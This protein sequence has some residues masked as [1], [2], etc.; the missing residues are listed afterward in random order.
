MQAS[1]LQNNLPQSTITHWDKMFRKN[2][3][4]Q[5]PFVA[6]TVRIDFPIH[7][8]N[9]YVM[10]MYP[11]LGANTNQAAEGVAP[12]SGITASVLQS[13]AVIGEY[14]D[15]ATFSSRALATAIDPV[16]ENIGTEM[17]YRLGQSDSALV[18]ITADAGTS[19]DSSILVKLA[20]TST[21]VF[22]TLSLNTI[23]NQV[24]SL[25]GRSVHP[26]QGYQNVFPGVI[27]PFALGD[28]LADT[29]NNSP[30]DIAKHTPAGF[31][32]LKDYVSS[33]I[34][35][36]IELPSS[37]VRFYQTNLVTQTANYNP[38]GGAITGLT[39]LRTYIFGMDGVFSYNLA[40]PGDTETGQ[41]EWQGIK[42]YIMQ[43]APMTIADPSGLIPGWCSYKQ[44]FTTSLGPDTVGRY[45]MVDGGSA[46][47]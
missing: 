40:A 31:E 42:P 8:G 2:L 4:A 26:L 14:A 18:R 1:N 21:S 33:D 41:G 24:Q 10:F 32:E 43:N 35:E 23:R 20:A 25:A 47:S 16:V 38:G 29:S 34:T 36:M 22:T 11:T 45:R 27:H 46:I 3:K 44:H 30:I 37:G 12:G 9:T 13:T 39:A 28:V 15:F 7:S 5:T 19:V 6:C 17:A